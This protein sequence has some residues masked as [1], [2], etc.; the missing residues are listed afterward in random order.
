MAKLRIIRDSGYADRLRAYQ[1]IVD[2]KQ[3]GD[4]RDG[5]T[6]EFPVSAGQHQLSLK[7]DWCGSKTVLFSVAEG[8]TVTFHAKSSLRGAMVFAA[9]WYALFDR[10]SYLTIEPEPNQLVESRTSAISGQRS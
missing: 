6:K 7:I 1:V 2:S 5:Q 4:L 3:V 10:H 9:L 8:D